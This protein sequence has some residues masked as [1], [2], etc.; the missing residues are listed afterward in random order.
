M[1][2]SRII[3]M[4]CALSV[5][6]ITLTSCSKEKEETKTK[7]ELITK[8]PW[9]FS[10][11]TRN[12]IDV[13][14][15]YPACLKDNTMTFATTGTYIED[16]GSTKCNPDDPQ[17]KTWNWHFG[18]NETKLVMDTASFNIVQL[19]ESSLILSYQ[20][21]LGSATQTLVISSVH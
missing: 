6:A 14:F 17:S 9:K 19:S 12:G 13:S 2:T 8:A 7:M 15:Y 11:I 20:I 18:E 3:F 5:A 4:L 21:V 16:E 1:K 10:S